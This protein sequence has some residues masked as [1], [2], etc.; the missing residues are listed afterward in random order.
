K[1]FIKE[2]IVLA[3][4]AYKHLSGLELDVE[5]DTLRLR[6]EQ[7]SFDWNKRM[8]SLEKE[9]QQELVSRGF[10]VDPCNNDLD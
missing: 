10:T 2:A 9:F 4:I 6:C 1:I 3:K 8:E 7:S 5:L